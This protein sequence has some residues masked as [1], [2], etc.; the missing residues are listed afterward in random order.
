M[1]DFTPKEKVVLTIMFQNFYNLMR[2]LDDYDKLGGYI[3][4]FDLNDLY[5]LA[6]KLGID[7]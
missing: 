5:F 2:N 6:G 4:G 3:E 1:V 7:Y